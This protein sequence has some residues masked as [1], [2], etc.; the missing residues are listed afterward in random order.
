[1]SGTTCDL[2]G[3]SQV[4]YGEVVTAKPLTVVCDKSSVELVVTSSSLLAEV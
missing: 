3:C 2:K 1:M 4:A